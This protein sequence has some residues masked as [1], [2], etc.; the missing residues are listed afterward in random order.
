MAQFHTWYDH[1]FSTANGGH[2]S[3]ALRVEMTN[4]TLAAPTKTTVAICGHVVETQRLR[5]RY[6]HKIKRLT[7][8]QQCYFRDKTLGLSGLHESAVPVQAGLRCFVQVA[9][10]GPTHLPQQVH[11]CANYLAGMFFKWG[12]H[13][14]VYRILHNSTLFCS[15]MFCTAMFC[16]AMFCTAMLLQRQ[17]MKKQS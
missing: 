5:T 14:E 11:Y 3:L 9:L 16:S 12:H 13:I 2:G 8:S 4:A 7:S 6:S 1:G 15:C 17:F 10:V